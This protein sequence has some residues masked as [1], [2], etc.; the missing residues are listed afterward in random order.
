MNIGRIRAQR[1]LDFAR[2]IGLAI[3]GEP[4]DIGETMIQA[5]GDPRSVS[6]WVSK[7]RIEKRAKETEKKVMA[8]HGS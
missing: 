2:A 4:G 1:T 7:A 6:K 8:K 3:S 5:G